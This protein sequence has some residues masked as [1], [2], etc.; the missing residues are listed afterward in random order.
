[1]RNNK[2]SPD[3]YFLLSALAGGTVFGLGIDTDLMVCAMPG[4]VLTILAIINYI[5]LV[6]KRNGGK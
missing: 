2:L 3:M 5:F 4:L 6:K 1:M